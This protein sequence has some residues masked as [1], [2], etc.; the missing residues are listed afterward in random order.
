MKKSAI[1]LITT[2]KRTNITKV[3]AAVLLGLI[4]ILGVS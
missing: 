1:D 4:V 3:A 2:N